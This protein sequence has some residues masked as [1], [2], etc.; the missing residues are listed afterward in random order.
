[1]RVRC[2]RGG[3][4][5]CVNDA[6][7]YRAATLGAGFI[8]TIINIIYQAFSAAWRCDSRGIFGRADFAGIPV[9][10]L[11]GPIRRNTLILDTQ[12]H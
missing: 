2:G 1:M 9:T 3:R 7:G 10:R 6:L 12:R 5:G 8:G 11:S 4:V